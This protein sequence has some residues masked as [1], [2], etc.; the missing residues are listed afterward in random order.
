MKL[1]NRNIDEL[2]TLIAYYK[3]PD[4]IVINDEQKRKL[5]N[6]HIAYDIY[7]MHGI[8]PTGLNIL[9]A[10][11]VDH[12]KL[13]GID[14]GI[15][16]TDTCRRLFKEVELFWGASEFSSFNNDFQKRLFYQMH[17]D[18]YL[19][20]VKLGDKGLL[21]S[22]KIMNTLTVITGIKNPNEGIDRDKLRPV[23]N[24]MIFGDLKDADAM[25]KIMAVKQMKDLNG[26]EK[27]IILNH[28]QIVHQQEVIETIFTD[29][30]EQ[31][32]STGDKTSS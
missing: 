23:M 12:Y 11:L 10:T 31:S 30:T 17:F 6:I 25:T 18:Q 26:N 32:E 21:I 15:L 14:I 24:V 29:V 20:A 9:R 4:S 16:S 7:R 2:E 19:R 8:G 22:D 27:A 28:I 1:A 3:D 13:K 5:N